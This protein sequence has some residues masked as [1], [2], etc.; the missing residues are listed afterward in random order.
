MVAY[1]PS[2]GRDNACPL[3]NIEIKFRLICSS[4]LLN[5][6]DISSKTIPFSF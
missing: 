3:Y 6:F 1:V 4:G 5:D 2:V